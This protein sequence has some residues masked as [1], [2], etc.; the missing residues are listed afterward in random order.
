MTG[1]GFLFDDGF[2]QSNK[3]LEKIAVNLG[4]SSK[5]AK[6]KK[7]F[8]G[9]NNFILNKVIRKYPFASTVG[10]STAAGYA[11]Y[12]MGQGS[13]TDMTNSSAYSYYPYS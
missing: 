13:N 3:Y 7:A 1:R 6:A 9:T 12:K 5:L 8:Q 2:M 11:G 4:S 10:A